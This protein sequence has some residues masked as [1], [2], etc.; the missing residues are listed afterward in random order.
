VTDPVDRPDLVRPD[1]V[2]NL[3][4]ADAQRA[5]VAPDPAVGA[6][7]GEAS[8]TFRRLLESLERLARPEGPPPEV[9]DPETLKR[10]LASADGDFQQVMDLRRRLEEAFRQRQP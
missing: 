9:R 7:A 5:P 1:L 2:R 3:P 4:L 6:T 8:P 10:A